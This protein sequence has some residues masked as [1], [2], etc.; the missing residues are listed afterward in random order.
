MDAAALVSMI[1]FAVLVNNPEFK[2]LTTSK[3]AGLLLF[4]GLILLVSSIFLLSP[5]QFGLAVVALGFA[6]FFWVKA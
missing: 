2:T 3:K 5:G 1:G 4:A 6:A